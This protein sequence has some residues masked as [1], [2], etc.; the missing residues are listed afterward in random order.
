MQSGWA[1]DPAQLFLECRYYCS[2]LIKWAVLVW[3]SPAGQ[4]SFAETRVNTGE[5]GNAWS[6]LVLELQLLAVIPLQKFS[7]VC[8]CHC[9]PYSWQKED[10]GTAETSAKEWAPFLNPS[11]FSRSCLS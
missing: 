9:L 1:T 6:P 10:F 11:A 8:Q 4:S 7:L 5:G 3:N 2:S